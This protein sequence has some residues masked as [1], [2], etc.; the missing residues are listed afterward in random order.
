MVDEFVLVV[1]RALLPHQEK[2]GKASRF[3]DQHVIE[4]TTWPATV[5]RRDHN[6][7]L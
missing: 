3:L 4:A 7:S 2:R 5:L 1:R 6:D